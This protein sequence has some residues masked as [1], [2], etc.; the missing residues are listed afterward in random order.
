MAEYTEYEPGKYGCSD[1]GAEKGTGHQ[2]WCQNPDNPNAVLDDEDDEVVEEGGD[3]RTW[4]GQSCG[5][6]TYTYRAVCSR[7][8]CIAADDDT[9]QTDFCDDCD[10]CKACGSAAA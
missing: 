6:P 1:C 7:D 10:S 4:C 2:N 3:G 5:D 8:E 9:G